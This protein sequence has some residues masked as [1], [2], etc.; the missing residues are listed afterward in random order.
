MGF[1][2]WGSGF[3]VCGVGCGVWRLVFGVSGVGSRVQGVGF[4]DHSSGFHFVTASDEVSGIR[5]FW[6]A[7][8]GSGFG[9]DDFGSRVKGSGFRVEG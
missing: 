6:F 3:V 1:G 2:V 5:H 7:V 8:Q 9:V 4:Q